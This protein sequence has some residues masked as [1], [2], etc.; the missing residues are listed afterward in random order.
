MV[1]IVT[2]VRLKEGSEQDWD[3]AMR[4]RMTAAAKRPGWVGG[5]L[6]QSDDPSADR[7]IVGTWRSR[8][9]WERWHDDPEFTKTRAQIDDLIAEPE[10]HAWYQVVVDARPA[11]PPRSSAPKRARK[12]ASPRHGE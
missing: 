11:T 4:E 1:S 7:V 2:N 10:Q 5:Q 9:D 12:P 6:L 8:A 3:A